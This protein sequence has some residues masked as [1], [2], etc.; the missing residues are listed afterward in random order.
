MWACCCPGCISPCLHMSC[1][2]LPPAAA[3]FAL[4]DTRASDQGPCSYPEAPAAASHPHPAG[5]PEAWE[6]QSSAFWVCHPLRQP[7]AAVWGKKPLG[8][9][10]NK[11]FR[12]ALWPRELPP[13][14]V[15]WLLESGRSCSCVSS[16]F[17]VSQSHPAWKRMGLKDKMCEGCRV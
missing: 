8:C 9:C 3:K 10:W 5:L 7:C 15:R 13:V 6:H 4:R 12:A 14:C 2:C 11:L 17:H 1:I 16:C